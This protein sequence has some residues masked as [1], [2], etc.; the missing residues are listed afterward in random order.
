MSDTVPA[1]VVCVIHVV[2]P[3]PSVSHSQLRAGDRYMLRV[4]D[5]KHLVILGLAVADHSIAPVLDAEHPDGLELLEQLDA[6]IPA[7][8][9]AP[10]ADVDDHHSE[11]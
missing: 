8:D 10:I 1:Q 6:L 4:D 9:H 5:A 7:P 2:C 11:A 3:H